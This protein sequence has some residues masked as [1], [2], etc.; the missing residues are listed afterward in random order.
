MVHR[1]NLFRISRSRE[2]TSAVPQPSLSNLL[3]KIPEKTIEDYRRFGQSLSPQGRHTRRALQRPFQTYLSPSPTSTTLPAS[4]PH[5]YLPKP[6]TT[7]QGCEAAGSG[8]SEDRHRQHA[9]PGQRDL[10]APL[11]RG[12]CAA[13]LSKTWWTRTRSSGKASE[14]CSSNLAA[15][16]THSV[17]TST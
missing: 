15:T 2:P 9:L 5:T 12:R 11:R 17:P 16:G 1:P 8:V 14:Q 6:G 7:T 10:I 3:S 4:E 13:C